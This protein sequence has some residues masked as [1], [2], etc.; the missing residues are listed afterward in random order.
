METTSDKVSVMFGGHVNGLDGNKMSVYEKSTM[1]RIIDLS[2]KPLD[3]YLDIP[4]KPC[5]LVGGE[6]Q[7]W[8]D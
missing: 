4:P 2:K 1:L 6:F 5:A 7:R 3:L 8:L